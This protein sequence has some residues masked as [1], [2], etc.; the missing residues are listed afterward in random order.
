MIPGLSAIPGIL[1]YLDRGQLQNTNY[2]QLLGL[3][4]TGA[5][6]VS[7][8]IS[9]LNQQ[10]FNIPR[11]CIVEGCHARPEMLWS[12]GCRLFA[13]RSLIVPFCFTSGGDVLLGIRC[14]DLPSLYPASLT[15]GAHAYSTCFVCLCVCLLPL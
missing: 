1:G 14:H 2:E 15:L 5:L 9:R 12:H 8:N 13:S 10:T 6:C 4:L 7:Q 3:Q 11:H